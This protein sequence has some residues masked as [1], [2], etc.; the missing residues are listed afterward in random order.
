MAESERNGARDRAT[1]AVVLVLAGAIL[2]VA[3]VTGQ[4]Q[5]GLLVLGLA[6]F[7]AYFWTREYGY[8]VPAGVLTGI[9][10]GIALVTSGAIPDSDTGGALFLVP[11]G[12]GFASI[13]VLDRLFTRAGNW[14]PLVPGAILVVIGVAVWQGGPALDLVALAGT[15]WPIVLIVVG[16][17]TLFQLWREGSLRG[18]GSDGE[19]G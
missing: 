4:W 3:Q 9:G 13:W 2:L 17:A 12:L 19:G 8:L 7:I 15:W 16:A 5:W 11:L 10:A 14:W 6:F 18:G 1:V